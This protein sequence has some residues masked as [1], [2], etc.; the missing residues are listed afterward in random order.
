MLSE[1]RARDD[2]VWYQFH[3]RSCPK[4]VENHFKWTVVVTYR[5]TNLLFFKIL[6]NYQ[7]TAKLQQAKWPSWSANL[8]LLKTV[9]FGSIYLCKLSFSYMNIIKS[10]YHSTKGDDHLKACLRLATSSSCPNY[11]NLAGSIQCRSSE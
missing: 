8:Y 11:A 2:T 5:F 1:R 10:M 6:F 7:A 4:Q 3:C 9:L